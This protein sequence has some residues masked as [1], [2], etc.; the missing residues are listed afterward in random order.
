M[1]IESQGLSSGRYAGGKLLTSRRLDDTI[2]PL[3][4]ESKGQI[5]SDTVSLI[6]NLV[7]FK[8]TYNSFT[9]LSCRP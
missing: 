5:D 3:D 7:P 9:K 8:L 4:F 2:C 1:E 6:L